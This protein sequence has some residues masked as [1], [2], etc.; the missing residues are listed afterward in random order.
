MA[1][2]SRQGADHLKAVALPATDAGGVGAHHHV[3]LHRPESE[4]PGR[5]QGVLGNCIAGIGHM[6]SQRE[7]VGREVVGAHHGPA[8]IHSH[9]H[10]LGVL[11]LCQLKEGAAASWRQL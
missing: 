2:R 3:E 1:K 8:P 6:G 10:R 5:L 4:P 7:G 9:H 11:Y